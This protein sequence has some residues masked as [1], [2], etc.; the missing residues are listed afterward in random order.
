MG[1][2]IQGKGRG[3]YH[4]IRTPDL[5]ERKHHWCVPSPEKAIATI[6]ALRETNVSCFA[7]GCQILCYGVDT[8]K[9]WLQQ[10]STKLHTARI[11]LDILKE[12]PSHRYLRVRG[13]DFGWPPSRQNSGSTP[14]LAQQ[15]M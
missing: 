7:A 8:D 3:G 9:A 11:M 4:S 10:D 5:D 6:S 1:S 15:I 13:G 12:V 2:L 14:I